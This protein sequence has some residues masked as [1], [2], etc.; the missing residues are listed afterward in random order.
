MKSFTGSASTHIDAGTAEVFDLVTDIGRLPEWNEAIESVVVQ[1]DALTP[2]D[3]WT[4]TMHPHRMPRWGSVSRLSSLDRERHRFSYETRNADGNPSSVR[5]AWQIEPAGDGSDV[6]VSWD[7]RLETLDRQY[8]AG[9]IRKRQLARE[10]TA[11]L[12]ALSAVLSPS[13][14]H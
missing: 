8:F 14:T 10:V 3:E 9:P 12:V 5:W 11:S 1:P 2:G 13:T 4:V 6:T 7:C